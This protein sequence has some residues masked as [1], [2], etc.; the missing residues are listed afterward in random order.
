MRRLLLLA[1]LTAALAPVGA[2]S[3]VQAPPAPGVETGQLG[4]ALLEAP[5]SRRDDPRA[6]IYVV[7]HLEPGDTIRRQIQVSNTTDETASVALYAASA[8]VQ[9]GAFTFGEGRAAN[10]LTRWTT[11]SPSSVSVPAGGSAT[12]Q[13]TVA[14]PPDAEDGERYGVVWAEQAA[15]AGAGGISSVSRV[16]IRM[17]VSV[18]EGAEPVSDFTV[19]QLTATRDADGA[20]VVQ[21]TVQNT[22]QR[23]L[24]MGGEL[25]LSDGPGGLK[26]GPFPASL[27]TTLG[28]GDE[29][30]VST[31]LD[32]ALPAGPWL[33]RITLRSGEVVRTVEGT[34]TFPDDAKPITVR[35]LVVAER[36]GGGD[37]LG[38]VVPTVAATLIALVLLFL[39]LLCRRRDGAEPDE[40]A[41]AAA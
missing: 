23:A 29:E 19:G 30:P 40:T 38:V 14:V 4:I 8:S 24:D 36:D 32:E 31:V 9:D 15:A 21:A 22:G 39:F 35:T 12:A 18:G 41:A 11:V 5:E 6:R 10:E 1:A 16:G 28:P 20:P 34:I 33:A 27:G 17:Y 26:A 13:V 37:D 3:A 2:V 7:D 25:S